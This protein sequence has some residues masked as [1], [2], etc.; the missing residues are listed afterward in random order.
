M[1]E[2]TISHITDRVIGHIHQWKN[3]RLEK[4]Y[5]VVWRDAI[6]FKVRQ[7]GKVI[8]K[9]VQIALGLNN[10]GRKEIPGMWICQNKSAAFRDE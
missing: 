8:D 9:S 3:R 7:E 10:N 2:A 5:M 4:V 6:V 1:S